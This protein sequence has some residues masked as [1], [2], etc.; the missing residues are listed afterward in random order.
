VTAFGL[1][2]TTAIPVLTYWITIGVVIACAAFTLT[3]AIAA[4]HVAVALVWAATVIFVVVGWSLQVFGHSVFEQRRP[5]LL[6]NPLHMLISPV[7]IVARL[8]VA[9]GFR[10][11]IAAVLSEQARDKAR[12]TE[13]GQRW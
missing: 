7:F 3:A 8:L 5:A 10:R 13:C 2:T 11:D 9:L 12:D 4:K 1:R 6:D